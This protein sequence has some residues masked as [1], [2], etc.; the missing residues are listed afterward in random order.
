MT[1]SPFTSFYYVLRV[2]EGPTGSDLR[3][4]RR[5]PGGCSKAAPKDGR[6]RDW[7]VFETT[8]ENVWFIF[9]GLKRMAGKWFEIW[10]WGCNIR[11]TT[12][13]TSRNSWK[14]SMTKVIL[15]W[16]PHYGDGL[17]KVGRKKSSQSLLRPCFTRRP[18]LLCWLVVWSC[19]ESAIHP[20]TCVKTVC[21]PSDI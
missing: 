11:K 3:S 9:G 5:L 12:Y 17:E 18:K 1:L 21:V 20:H 19:Y 14:F 13:F 10:L 7:R 6:G 8:R 4:I 15:R 2:F 16:F